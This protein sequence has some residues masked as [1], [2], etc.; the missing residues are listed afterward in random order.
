MYS[1]AN[2]KS[3][4][5]MLPRFYV[6]SIFV[7]LDSL[8][9]LFWLLHLTLAENLKSIFKTP[10]IVKGNKALKSEILSRS[11]PKNLTEIADLNFPPLSWFVL[12]HQTCSL[13]FDS[14]FSNH[15]GRSKNVEMTCSKFPILRLYYL[16]LSIKRPLFVY[17]LRATELTQ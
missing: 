2:S 11:S 3:K 1:S 14:K 5:K 15:G 16:Y 7:C 6:K 13:S 10:K 8:K 17:L 12:N 4:I 9:M